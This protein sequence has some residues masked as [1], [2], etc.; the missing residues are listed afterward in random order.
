[1][2]YNTMQRFESL[3]RTKQLSEQEREEHRTQLLPFLLAELTACQ[4]RFPFLILSEYSTLEERAVAISKI[5]MDADQ[6]AQLLDLLLQIKE[7]AN[8]L[9]LHSAQVCYISMF[10]KEQELNIPSASTKQFKLYYPDIIH[11]G[12]AGLLHDIGKF[13]PQN[14]TVIPYKE[15]MTATEKQR[16][17]G[18]VIN[19]NGLL[20]K[21]RLDG[22]IIQGILQHH[23]TLDGRGFPL[24]L[25]GDRIGIAGKILAIADY[26]AHWMEQ[27]EDPER[28]DPFAV[29]YILRSQN[30][31]YDSEL[32]KKFYMG[33]LNALIGKEVL[34]SDGTTAKLLS[35]NEKQPRK[36][37]IE[38]QG[39][40]YNLE[41]EETTL[42]IRKLLE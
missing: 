35:I 24:N 2:D 25:H 15:N 12:V 10:L 3:I 27:N 26:Y 1:M 21:K 19:S 36:S 8:S 23:E 16:Y 9:F 29:S 17:R 42:E 33:F 5:L 28:T 39:K 32:I 41:R 11:L 20:K 4:K 14:G 34:L 30:I 7:Q 31:L 37:R 13:L 40:Q 6:D 18:H 22:N 38:L